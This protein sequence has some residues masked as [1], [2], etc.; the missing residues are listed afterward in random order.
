MGDRAHAQ[1]AAIVFGNS[2]VMKNLI[3]IELSEK[4]KIPVM[5]VKTMTLKDLEEKVSQLDPKRDRFVIVHCLG[6]DANMISKMNR[7]HVETEKI[8]D[9]YM[10]RFCEVV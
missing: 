9:E 5:P 4:L 6:N 10:E 8:V 2:N 7:N 1:K 3:P